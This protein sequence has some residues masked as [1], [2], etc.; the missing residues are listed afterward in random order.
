M[1]VSICIPTFNNTK[2][3]KDCLDSVYL[4]GENFEYEVLIG[5]DGCENTLE[6]IK[7]L[8]LNLIK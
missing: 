2:Y 3:L 7:T 4:S 8:K 6:Y 5:I 1:I